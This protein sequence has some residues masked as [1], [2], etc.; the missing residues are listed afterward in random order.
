MFKIE[1][2]VNDISIN[3]TSFSIRQRIVG[4]KRLHTLVLYLKSQVAA[5]N[6]DLAYWANIHKKAVKRL[7]LQENYGKEPVRAIE[8]HECGTTACALGHAATIPEFKRKGLS[9]V[10]QAGLNFNIAYRN[11]SKN[12]VVYDIEAAEHFFYLISDEASSI[13]YPESYGRDRTKQAVIN[14]IEAQIEKMQL[15]VKLYK[16]A[17]TNNLPVTM[18]F[19]MSVGS[20]WD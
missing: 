9:I 12:E 19:S 14:R 15:E 18:G 17:K 2:M 3:G 8:V 20:H 7:N 11:P 10:C 13:F 4:V 16:V 6:F 1:I 5:E